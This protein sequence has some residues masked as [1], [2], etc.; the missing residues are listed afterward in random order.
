MATYQNV[1]ANC[2]GAALRNAQVT[3]AGARYVL[4]ACAS[5]LQQIIIPSVC[6]AYIGTLSAVDPSSRC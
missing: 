6:W 1:A 3:A 2:R 4:R 5:T